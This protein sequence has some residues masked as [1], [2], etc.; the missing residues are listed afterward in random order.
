[1][2]SIPVLKTRPKRHKR[3][4]QEQENEIV[5][6]LKDNDPLLL[7]FIQFISYSILRPIEI[8]RLKVK[9]VNIKEKTIQF[10]E[11]DKP[12][13]TKLIPQ[14]LLDALPDLT[15]LDPES[16]LFTP[17]GLGHVW[18]IKDDN[19]RGYFSDRFKKVVKDTFGLNENYGLYSYKHTYVTKLHNE[20]SKTY[21][22]NETLDRLMQITGHA[23]R[24]A[25]KAYL[26]D[27]D[28]DL[29]EDYSYLLKQAN[30]GI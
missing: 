21:T 12:R 14:I 2:K 17:K 13:K 22:P 26:R 6:H 24:K 11:K 30:K 3:F 28:A 18:N 8:C 27:I 1:M 23:T 25:L 15:Q 7:L 20:F 19:K 16:S 10:Q 29:P 5:E 4:T 9:D